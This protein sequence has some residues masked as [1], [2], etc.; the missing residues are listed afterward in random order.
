MIYDLVLWGLWTTLAVLIAP[1]A[2]C[3]IVFGIAWARGELTE[4][5]TPADLLTRWFCAKEPS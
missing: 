1:L 4:T 2:L 3:W 5:S